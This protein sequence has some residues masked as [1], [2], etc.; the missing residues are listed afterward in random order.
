MARDHFFTEDDFNALWGLIEENLFKI[1]L[2]SEEASKVLSCNF[3]QL[4]EEV[5]NLLFLNLWEG[6]MDSMV[7]M[8]AY[9]LFMW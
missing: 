5:N 7:G 6:V 8:S 2:R 9:I 4:L 1:P 3:V